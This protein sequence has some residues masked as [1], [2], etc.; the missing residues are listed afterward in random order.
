M[1]QER[2][3]TTGKV[4]LHVGDPSGSV[5][6]STHD[7]PETVV[8]LTM[9]R[10]GVDESVLDDARVE[11]TARDGG[12]DVYVEITGNRNGLGSLLRWLISTGGVDVAVRAPHGT[13]LDIN[14]A[15]ANIVARGQFVDASIKTASGSVRLDDAAG[16][17]RIRTASGSTE[18][19]SLRRES[20]INSASG[21]VHV[22]S[23]SADTE[24]KT[25]SGRIDVD[26]VRSRLE[27]RSASGSVEI[28]TVAGDLHVETAAGRLHVGS[29]ISGEATL[30][31]VSGSVLVGVAQGTALHVD[32][33]AI[34]GALE[35]EIALD[36]EPDLSLPSGPELALRIRSV[37]GRVRI[38]RAGAEHA[39]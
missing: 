38:V 21:S 18:C 26:E 20:S 4:R 39:V 10:P 29:F 3:A 16:E 19:P 36:D 25:A 27:V 34:S 17:V 35:S 14:T 31:T 24:I 30:T 7:E 2:F 37:S 13:D 15:S 5:E 8:E 28:G 32:A 11:S 1:R 12:H 22:G 6:V 9:T 33:E 23:V